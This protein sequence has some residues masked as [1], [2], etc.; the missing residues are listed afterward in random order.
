MKPASIA[1]L[2][3]EVGSEIALPDGGCLIRASWGTKATKHN[4]ILANHNVFRLDA[5]GNVVWQV[6]RE[7]GPHVDWAVR[8]AHAKAED[9]TA[10]GYFD[11]FWSLGMDER[12]ALSPEPAGVFRPGCKVYLTTRW[13]SYELDVETGIATCTGNQVK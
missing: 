12:G 6:T 2:D 11:P 9:P 4:V 13:W 5:A 3:I 7:E 8:H 1:D 10:E